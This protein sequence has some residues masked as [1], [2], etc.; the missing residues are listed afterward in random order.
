VT[1]TEEA[2]RSLRRR[3]GE[4]ENQRSRTTGELRLAIVGTALAVAMVV[5]TATTWVADDGEPYTLWG[6]VPG[7]WQA[8]VM[9]TLVVGVAVATP[10]LFLADQ[11]SRVGHLLMVWVSLLTAIWVIVINA[12]VPEDVD[13]APG[14]WLTLLV[15]LAVAAVHGFRA[16]ETSTRPRLRDHPM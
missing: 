5:L 10:A 8:L 6:L 12:V 4:L 14:R 11:P 9:L 7:G 2:L 16:E 13:T 1:D 15:A 3:L